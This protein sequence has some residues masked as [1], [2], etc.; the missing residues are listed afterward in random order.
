MTIESR[1]RS[2]VLVAALAALAACA[3]P[4]PESPAPPKAATVDGVY[5]GTANGSCGASQPATMDL[6]DGRFTLT[7]APDLRL[8]GHADQDGTLTATEPYG[9]G[10]DINFTGRIDGPKLRGGSYNGRCAFAFAMVRTS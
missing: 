1:T 6:K 5:E 2:W 9:D 7:V 4:A 8:R 3:Q 10:R